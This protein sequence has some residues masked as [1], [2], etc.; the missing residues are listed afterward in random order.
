MLC[1]ENLYLHFAMTSVTTLSSRTI[2]RQVCAAIH[3][4]RHSRPP[5]V[6]SKFHFI[7]IRYDCQGPVLEYNTNHKLFNRRL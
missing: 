6:K 3:T 7:S 5:V 2:E 4:A 1:S